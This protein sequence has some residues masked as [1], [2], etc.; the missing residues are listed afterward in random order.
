MRHLTAF[1]AIVACVCALPLA[2]EGA[3]SPAKGS[4][5][6]TIAERPSAVTYGGAVTISGQ[7]KG[8]HHAGKTVGLQA[9]PYPF[10]GF[11][12]RAVVKTDSKGAYRF[13]VK[14]VRHTRYRAVTPSPLTVY[15]TLVKS[16]EVLVHV[17]LRVGIRLSDSTP[18]RGSRVRFFGSVAP[19][20]NGRAVYIQRRRRDGRW[21]TIARTKTRN[22]TGNRS[23]YSKRVRIFRTGLYRVRVRGHADH[24]TGTSRRRLIRVH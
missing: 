16:P 13:V 11:T 15:D 4:P 12:T 17:R 20:H 23:V 10:K 3:K 5:S 2:A 24:S 6:L 14:P 7:L 22:A 21:V 18:R 8:T 19:K 1:L 9:N